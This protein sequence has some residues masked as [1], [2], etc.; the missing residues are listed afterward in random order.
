MI[1][2]DSITITLPLP[3]A[4]LSPN[5]RVVWQARHRA[6]E[7][8][9]YDASVVAR[10]EARR[11]GWLPVDAATVAV[12]WY[13]WRR[14]WPDDTNMRGWLKAYEDGF[15]GVL[16]ED[17]NRLTWLPVDRQLDRERPRVE[18]TLYRATAGRPG[19][20]PGG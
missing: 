10:V 7:R 13:S 17:D 6:T 19:A 4:A 11:V 16:I 2:P 3:P 12:V 8:A 15:Q 1:G 9:R 5:A 20:P 18:I 14:R